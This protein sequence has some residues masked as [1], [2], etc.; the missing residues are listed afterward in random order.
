M[1]IECQL[2]QQ[3]REA[4]M[5]TKC[6]SRQGNPILMVT[7]FLTFGFAH[8]V[9][10]MTA[11]CIKI[12]DIPIHPIYFRIRDLETM[13]TEYRHFHFRTHLLDPANQWQAK[14]RRNVEKYTM[15]ACKFCRIHTHV[16]EQARQELPQ[17]IV[18]NFA[19]D[20]PAVQRMLAKKKVE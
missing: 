7:Q 4:K 17:S 3:K 6:M 10:T 5:I 11:S 9:M 8:T 13:Q 12:S 20:F 18:P 2:S 15:V 19:N 16:I 1:E 14:K